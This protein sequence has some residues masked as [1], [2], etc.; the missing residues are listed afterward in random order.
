MRRKDREM[1]KDFA[2]EIVDKC[3]WAT[4]AMLN[5]QGMPYCIPISIVRVA[6]R[7]YFHS[8]QEGEK[9]NCLKNCLLT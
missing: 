8:A 2:L 3:E 4:I 7:I 5:E 6:D 1:S 9:I